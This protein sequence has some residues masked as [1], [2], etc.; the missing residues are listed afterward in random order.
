V[1]SEATSV[2][3]MVMASSPNQIPTR[4]EMKSIG[5]KTT[6]VVAVEAATERNISLVP[7]IA[8]SWGRLPRSMCR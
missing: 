5:R 1:K 6:T 7:K 4:P 8:A 3:V 2:T